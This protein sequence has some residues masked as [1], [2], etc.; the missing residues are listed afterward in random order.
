MINFVWYIWNKIYFVKIFSCVNFL[1]FNFI[2]EYIRMRNVF[3]VGLWLVSIYMYNS[4]YGVFGKV[5]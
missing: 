2:Y 3:Y 5:V 1:V 4:G